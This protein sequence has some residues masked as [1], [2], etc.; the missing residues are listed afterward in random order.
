MLAQS[1]KLPA[2]VSAEAFASAQAAVAE[3]EQQ[4]AAANA[5]A[6]SGNVAEAASL[7]SGVKAKAAQ[8]MTVLGMDV[9]EALRS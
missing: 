4:W 3:M 8:V 5:A 7:A 2:N 9:P 1:R 6:Q